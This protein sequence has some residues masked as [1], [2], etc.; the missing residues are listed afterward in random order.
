MGKDF[1]GFK[2]ILIIGLGLIG[3]SVALSLRKEGYRGKIYGFDLNEY[4]IKKAVEM[5]AIDKGFTDIE[6]IPWDEI[7]LVILS[8]PVKTFLTIAENIKRYLRKDTV[9]T[10]VGSVKGEL[11]KKLE[12]ILKPAVFIGAHPIAGTEKEGVENAVVGLFKGKKVILT[13]DHQDEHTERI[14]KFW[15]D[16]GS[17]VEIMDPFVHDFVFAAV[18]HLPHAVAFAL[19]DA[20][21][22]LSKERDIDL[23]LYPGAGF[24]DFTRIAA[25]SP[26]VWKDIFIENKEEVLHTIDQF[27]K[28]MEKLKDYIKNEDE[29]KLIDLLSESRERRLSLD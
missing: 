17:K 9:V 13:V 19:V 2:S 11:V 5:G 18:S 29:K 23:F 16:L 10:D 4:R 1:G 25:S 14:K 26:V 20:L 15:E 3:G 24:K 22:E 6:S 12:E 21:I 27:I 8:T 7:D 28:S